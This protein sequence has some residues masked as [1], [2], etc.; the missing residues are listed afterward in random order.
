VLIGYF[1]KRKKELYKPKG[2][3][4]EVKGILEVAKEIFEGGEDEIK[5]ELCA[6]LCAMGRMPEW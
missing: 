3:V 1:R 4:E 2:I 5:N 6:H